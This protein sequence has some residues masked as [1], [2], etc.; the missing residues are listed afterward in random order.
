MTL[1]EQVVSVSRTY[2]GPATEAFIARQ[3]KSHLKKESAELAR[4]DMA[5]LAK[6]MEIGAGLLMD[7]AK[8]AELATK[9]RGI[10]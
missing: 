4:A 2:L 1:Y 7:Q 10:Q 6:W 3:C 5:T 9:V 8:A